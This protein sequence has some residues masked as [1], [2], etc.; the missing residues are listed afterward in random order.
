MR[1]R[2]FAAALIA[3]AVSFAAPLRAGDRVVSAFSSLNGKHAVG[4]TDSESDKDAQIDSFS[5]IC[6]GFAGFELIHLG[7]DLRS[8]LKLRKGKTET[9]LNGFLNL[10]P[11]ECAWEFP[12]VTG[13]LVEWRGV[14]KG[15][16]FHPYAIIFRVSGS[17]S[18]KGD[19]PVTHSCLVVAS[20]AADGTAKL[21]G[22]A[23]GKDEDKKAA[24]LADKSK[25]K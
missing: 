16:V 8:W 18:S 14:L 5:N 23:M 20:I 19:K 15:E 2:L 9:E 4:V 25:E 6:P 11:K 7:G 1:T 24:A 10:L 3:F 22:A 17:D 12:S 21:V 13:E